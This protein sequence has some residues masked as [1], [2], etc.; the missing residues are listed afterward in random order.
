MFYEYVGCYNI[1]LVNNSLKGD[2][3]KGYFDAAGGIQII[4]QAH[5]L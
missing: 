1:N 5:W 3:T 4:G 2:G